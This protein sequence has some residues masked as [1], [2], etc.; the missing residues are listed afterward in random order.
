[1]VALWDGWT[2]GCE[3]VG[4]S[5]TVKK[6]EDPFFD[7]TDD[8]ALVREPNGPYQFAWCHASTDPCSAAGVNRLEVVIPPATVTCNFQLD[9]AIGAPLETVGPRGS[10]YAI[11]ARQQA[12][13]AG[14]G[15]FNT[16]GP[17]ML[18]DAINQGLGN[19]VQQPRI[20]IDKQWVGTGATPPTNVPAAFLLT[21]TS[22]ASADDSTVLGTAICNVSGGVFTCDYRDQTDPT[23]P[24]PGLVVNASSVLTV[25][26]TGFPGNTVDV[27]FPVS[28]SSRFVTCPSNGGPCL[29]T[30]TNTPPP[31]P[32][33]T[34]TQAP[35][36]T[37]EPPTEPTTSPATMPATLPATGSSDPATL[38]VLGALLVP[39]GV[40]LIVITRLRA[41]TRP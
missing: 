15:T 36:P 10:Y 24:Q 6:T 17:S 19:C 38:L 9:L 26:E 7:L 3:N 40:A 31:P 25:T 21:V 12:Q 28:A 13:A 39:L 41:R 29:F 1:V 33:T 5:M 35:A 2:P 27:T 30:I 4:I 23:V 34:T 20:V 11:S 22:L 37:T 18:L 8:Q 14:L 32:V 16:T